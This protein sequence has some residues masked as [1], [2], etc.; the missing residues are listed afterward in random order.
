[1]RFENLDVWKR[2]SRLC[3][4]VYKEL[5]HCKDYGFKDQKH[6]A[7]Y[8]SQ[9]TLQRALSVIQKKMVISS[10]IMRKVLAQNYEPKFI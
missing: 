2:S 8:Q 9:A 1:M 6:V 5:T 4:E 7:A 3:V 10:F